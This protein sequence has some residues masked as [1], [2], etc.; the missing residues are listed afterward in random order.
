MIV[1]AKSDL[2]RILD[3]LRDEISCEMIARTLVAHDRTLALDLIADAWLDELGFALDYDK[4][5]HV[6]DW[7]RAIVHR[8]RTSRAVPALLRSGPP[9][10][11]SIL[12]RSGFSDPA[13]AERLAAVESLSMS[14]PTAVEAPPAPASFHSLRREDAIVDGLLER[15]DLVDPFTSEHSRAVGAWCFRIAQRLSFTDA[16]AAFVARCGTLHDLGKI[17]TPLDVLRAPRALTHDEWCV[18]R[19]HP[20]VGEQLVHEVPLLREIAP[21]VRQHHE[22]LD[23]RGYPDGVPD[24]GISLATRIVTV[25]DCFNAMIGRR[26]YRRPMTP[27]TA[28]DQL[29]THAGTQFDATIVEAMIDVVNDDLS[30]MPLTKAPPRAP[31]MLGG[32][33]R[34]D[35]T[36]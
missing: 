33:R 23:G 19:E 32:R 11:R 14:L 3:G 1:R 35:R 24:R 2:C 8:Y 17:C 20:A 22:R 10:V 4:V 16:D 13:V 18:M 36:A 34:S 5:D 21:I 6:H 27:Q 31:R 28:I 30:P 26:P 12:V 25:A 15:M 9:I 7:S 29:R